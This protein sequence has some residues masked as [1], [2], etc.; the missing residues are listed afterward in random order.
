MKD[1]AAF[2]FLGFIA[3]FCEFAVLADV[4][5]G[6]SHAQSVTARTGIADKLDLRRDRQILD[7]LVPLGT[8]HD[9][10]IA[11]LERYNFQLQSQSVS[12]ASFHNL[13]GAYRRKG[14]QWVPLTPDDFFIPCDEADCSLITASQEYPSLT[15]LFYHTNRYL[16]LIVD[17]SVARVSVEHASWGFLRK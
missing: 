17:G 1:R 3:V 8:S 5:T 11:I 16:W 14:G 9:D 13:N 10:L 6:G 12:N 7:E 2:L 15:G 4:P